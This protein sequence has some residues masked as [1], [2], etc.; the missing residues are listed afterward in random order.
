M[1]EVFRTAS[2]APAPAPEVKSDTT[3]TAVTSP[4]SLFATYQDSVGHPYSADYYGMPTHWRDQQGGF[5]V[6]I[7]SIETYLRDLV[8]SGD[9]DNSTEAAKSKLTKL[10]K[11]A[12]VDKT[13]SARGRIRQVA[14]YVRYLREAKALRG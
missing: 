4:S 12:G 1:S 9:L 11:E 13:M 6:E 8:S 2:E 7:E 14:A 10:E 5:P 3:S